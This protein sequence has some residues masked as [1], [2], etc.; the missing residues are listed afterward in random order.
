MTSLWDP[1]WESLWL[2]P[3]AEIAAHFT[4]WKDPK[5]R[6]KLSTSSAQKPP[7]RRLWAE[8][9]AH[10]QIHLILRWIWLIFASGET[11]LFK[12][13][14]LT[15]LAKFLRNFAKKLPLGLKITKF[16]EFGDFGLKRPRIREGCPRPKGA[17]RRLFGLETGHQPKIW[18]FA[19]E[20]SK[21]NMS[22]F[23]QNL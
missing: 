21:F 18:P 19:K 23:W 2:F 10:P 15:L 9:A 14:T 17:F 20:N 5:L 12:D 22:N 3:R 8:I 11:G 1:L 6:S 7:F 16:Y 13:P 4:F